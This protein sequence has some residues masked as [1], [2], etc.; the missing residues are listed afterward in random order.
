M[1]TGEHELRVATSRAGRNRVW[2]GA[3]APPA[4]AGPRIGP[5]PHGKKDPEDPSATSEF[6]HFRVYKP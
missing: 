2:G 5:I 3:W 1:S 6:D 4:G